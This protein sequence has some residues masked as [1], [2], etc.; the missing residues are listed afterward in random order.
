MPTSLN[1][2][3]SDRVKIVRTASTALDGK[4]GTIVGVAI[5]DI[6]SIYIVELDSLFYPRTQPGDPFEGFGPVKC[7][8]ITEACLERI[9]PTVKCHDGSHCFS[10]IRPEIGDVCSCGERKWKE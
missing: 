3:Y 9:P 7:L 8:S 5:R 10:G 4:R 6:T 1:L 2:K